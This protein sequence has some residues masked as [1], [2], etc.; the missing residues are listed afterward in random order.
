MIIKNISLKNFRNIKDINFSPDKEMNIICG[1]NAQGKTNII[2]AIWLLT[3]AKSF[4]SSKDSAFIKFGEKKAII[5]SVFISEDIEKEEKIE[6]GEKK[7]VLLNGKKISL[8]SNIAGNF[9]AIVFSPNDLSIVENGPSIRRKFCDTAIGQLYPS[10][11]SILREYNRAVFQRNCIIKDYKYDASVSV[12]LDVFEKEIAEKGEKI[13]LYRKRFIESLKNF[14][15]SI[16]SEISGGREELEIEYIPSFSGEN[17]EE[18]LKKARKEDM[19]CGCT[20]LGPHRDDI[21]FRINGISARLFASQGQK[22]SIAIALKLSEAEVINKI[23][24][25]YPVCLL[26]DIMS[27][28]DPLRQNYILNHIKGK[29]VFLSCCDPSNIKNLQKGKIFN[30]EKGEIKE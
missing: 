29:Q 4:R 16:Y 24:G 19:N 15:G 23:S 30:I 28:L 3:G 22:R 2:E 10:F 20:S 5:S 14:L 7:S 9:R 12:M 17:L 26:D 6:I 27:E 18:E 11:I 13:I 25:E 8:A 1:E 21:E